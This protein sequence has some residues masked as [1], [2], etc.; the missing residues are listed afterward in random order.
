MSQYTCDMLN[1]Q[2]KSETDKPETNRNM[3]KLRT[4]QGYFYLNGSKNS[5]H[6]R[7]YHIF[8]LLL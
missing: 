7:T 3:E 5:F 8:I 4:E 2:I 1:V 6:K